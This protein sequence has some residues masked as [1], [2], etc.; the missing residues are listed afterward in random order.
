MVTTV[1][2]DPSGDLGVVCDY[3]NPLLTLPQRI[4]GSELN[5]RTLLH[6]WS[7]DLMY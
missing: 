4:Q 3:A 2:D 5:L 6:G 7:S 1:T